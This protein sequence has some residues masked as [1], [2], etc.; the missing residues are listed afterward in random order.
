M[1]NIPHLKCQ[2]N[3]LT[4]SLV[5]FLFGVVFFIQKNSSFIYNQEETLGR[6]STCRF[7]RKKLEGRT[8]VSP[9][10]HCGK[11]IAIGDDRNISDIEDEDR[12]KWCGDEATMRGANQR[13]ITYSLYGNVHNA[14]IFRRYY[15][16]LRN[17]SLTAEKWYPGWTIRIYHNIREQPG[18]EMEAF[19][20]LCDIYCRYSNVDL[21]SVPQLIDRIGVNNTT[22]IDP[23]LLKGL[24]PKMFR[25]LVMM[26]PDVD[27]FISR[28]VDSIIWR[29]EVDAVHQWLQSN[30]TFHLMRDHTFHG[31]I[32]LAGMW[33]AKLHQRRD[34]IE[35]LM[36]AL[37]LAGQ[38]QS[39]SQDQA[40]LDRIVW[41]AAK[42]DVVSVFIILSSV[43]ITI[44]KSINYEYVDLMI[45]GAR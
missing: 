17:I 39:G 10:C 7:P 1:V 29:R 4:Y 33:G 44:H 15:S 32:I 14:S 40:S 9:L 18:P 31:S 30:Y 28:D 5:I 34:L 26:D 37:V 21:C 2:R 11:E 3:Q 19:R 45:D 24:N 27:T 38:D 41:P 22:P 16:V 36:R 6:N 42:F 13:I 43:I 12:F 8:Y 35:G 25:Y 23:Q 20:N